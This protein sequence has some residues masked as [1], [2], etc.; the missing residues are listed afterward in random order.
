MRVE[1]GRRV[2]RLRLA[3]NWRLATLSE[4]AGLSLPTLQRFE[5]T[6]RITLDN[7]LKLADALGRLGEV[8]ALFRPPAARSLAQLERETV[9][10]SP[11]R[12][13]R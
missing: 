8:E 12:G 10:P 11:Q 7:L 9:E 1:L 2:R 3:R 4:R 5:T 6:G 13:R